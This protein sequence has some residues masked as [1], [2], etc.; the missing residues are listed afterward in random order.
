MTKEIKTLNEY[1]VVDRAVR[2]RDKITTLKYR[3]YTT[4]N[5]N[6]TLIFASKNLY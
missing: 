3:N 1:E 5:I 6:V 2:A 4:A